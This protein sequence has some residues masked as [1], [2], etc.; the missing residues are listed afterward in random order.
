[1]SYP[2]PQQG[3][4]QPAPPVDLDVHGTLV[5]SEAR[6]AGWMRF[7]VL[8]QGKQ[9]PYKADT[10]KPEVIQQAMSLMGQPV[11]ISVREQDS[12][13]RN[14]HTGLPYKN[15]YLNAIAPMGY[16]P[17]VQPS[18][19][20]MQ[21]NSPPGEYTQQ[22][23]PQQQLQQ[24]QQPVQQQQQQQQQQQ[25]FQPGIAGYDKDINIMRQC[26]SKCAVMQM[27]ALPAEQR[28]PLG[29]IA[30]AETWM[31]YYVYGPLRFGLQP[32]S[33]ID[34]Q[35]PVGGPQQP[36]HPANNPQATG[37][38]YG[39]DWDGTGPCPDCQFTGTHAL[40]CPRGDA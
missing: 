10:K 13:E 2:Q 5:G 20:H 4:Q 40:G 12:S 22:Q 3:Y 24:Q 38:A 25:P 35:Q 6:N 7:L 37:A 33:S 31:A 17:G 1:M 15:R 30:A 21:Q 19:Q 29:L 8:E 9:Y 26:A 16:A 14:P 18:P 32:F 23:Q 28:T 39:A 34:G 36:L 11:S 27:H